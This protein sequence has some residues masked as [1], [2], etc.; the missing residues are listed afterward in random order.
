MA[1]HLYSSSASGTPNS[2]KSAS[3]SESEAENSTTGEVLDEGPLY[4]IDNKFSSE[5]D[6]AEIMALAEVEREAILA[7]RAQQLER[8]H[9]DGILRRL[10]QRYQT[11]DGEKAKNLDSKK[12]KADNADVEDVQRKS[13][14]QKTTL[15]GR[16]V[17]ETSDAM[18]AYKRQR[19]QKGIINEQRKREGEERKERK[20]RGSLD[21]DSEADADGESEVDWNDKPKDSKP[22][23]SAP[24]DELPPDLHD[25]SRVKIS[26][27]NFAKVCFYPGFDN[28]IKDCF[29]RV[30]IGPDRVTGETL[31]RMC[32]IKG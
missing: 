18:E 23:E 5:K 28:A 11:K 3:M 17:G 9:Q 8:Q 2:L 16:K 27:E 24:R 22:F 1:S 4:P 21:R 25:F 12:R 31:Y 15:G 14:R 13:S 20:K 6:K 32:Q 19:E 30:S 7:E 26:R 10:I 29:A